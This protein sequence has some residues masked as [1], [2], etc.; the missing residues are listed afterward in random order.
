MVKWEL[1]DEHEKTWKTNGL[2]DLKYT[3]LNT[4]DMDDTRHSS[5]ITVDVRL[6]I[7]E[8]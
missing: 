6:N 7:E 4:Q 5:K 2:A 8:E 1:A 3:V